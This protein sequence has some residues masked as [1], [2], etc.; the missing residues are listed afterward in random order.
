[1]L[2]RVEP[3]ADRGRELGGIL[4]V[5]AAAAHRLDDLVVARVG[6]LGR[7]G[8][9]GAEDHDLR[10]AG[11]PP[12]G[13]VGGDEGDGELEVDAALRVEAVEAKAAVAGQDEDLAAGVEL[14]RGEGEGRAD[15]EA[16]ERARVEPLAGA[17]ERDDARAEG[18]AVAAVADEDRVVV[19]RVADRP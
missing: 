18:H 2:A 7:G 3:G 12:R 9:L 14:L 1:D 13:V 11:L 8:A 17:L 10:A 5:V 16:A 15:A 19:D 4:D 6:E